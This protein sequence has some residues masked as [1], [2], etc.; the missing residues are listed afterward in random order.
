M[1]DG[2]RETLRWLWNHVKRSS[3]AMKVVYVVLFGLLFTVAVIYIPLFSN[4]SDFFN[5][6]HPF[7][8]SFV[9][10]FLFSGI[11]FSVLFSYE[12]GQRVEQ[13][14]EKSD[15]LEKEVQEMTVKLN[16]AQQ[17]TRESEAR[18]NALVEVESRQNIWKRPCPQAAPQFFPIGQRGSR[19]RFLSMI[20]LKGGVGKTTV[21]ANLAACLAAD[22]NPLRVLLVDLDFQGNLSDHSV[23][24]QLVRLQG[25]NAN[26]VVRLLDPEFDGSHLS[27]IFTPMLQV[28]GAKVVLATD[29]LENVDFRLQAEYF[30]QPDREVRFHF[31]KHLHCPTVFHEFD[32]VIFDC[33][34][35]LT[36]SAVNALTCSDYVLIPTKLDQD[37]INSVP[38]TIK[39]L[40]Q[41]AVVTS[42][43]LVGV[44]A[45]D[46]A[47]WS[48]SLTRADQNSYNY[49]C[50][51]VA[52]W[53][54]GNRGFVLQST[55]K[56]DSKIPP[57]TRGLVACATAANRE[58][59]KGFVSELRQRINL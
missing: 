30:V 45:N 5:R 19:T 27:R 29:E 52:Q 22:E 33:P 40:D 20:N 55:I 48:G 32:L 58:M 6:A 50:D 59:F 54:A 21:T 36:T 37:S 34:P 28:P 43:Q 15:R 16:A 1:L 2:S 24:P 25:L 38:R 3:P 35:R 31:R 49:L 26:T 39:W 13:L 23:D 9:L 53:R 7:A 47:L 12:R 17:A 14:K 44:L 57:S 4:L 18:W 8:Q 46:V 56:S 51:V 11:I 42:A 10:V 41:L